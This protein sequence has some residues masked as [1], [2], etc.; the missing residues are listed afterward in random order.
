VLE[1]GSEAQADIRRIDWKP[2]WAE[3]AKL[4]RSWIQWLFGN[5]SP[6]SQKSLNLPL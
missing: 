6:G 3:I 1:C 4:W 2:G 5:R